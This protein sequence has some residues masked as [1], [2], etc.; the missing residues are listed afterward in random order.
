MGTNVFRIPGKEW[1]VQHSQE[2]GWGCESGDGPHWFYMR[3]NYVPLLPLL[4]TPR[5]KAKELVAQASS[6]HVVLAP[7]PFE[8]FIVTALHWPTEYWPMLAVQWLE[9]DFPLSPSVAECLKCISNNKETSQRLRHRAF[10]LVV[11]ER[12]HANP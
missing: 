7:F 5:P 1:Y 4:D 2:N 10:G 6:M 8:D 11:R 12:R 9:Q 3:G